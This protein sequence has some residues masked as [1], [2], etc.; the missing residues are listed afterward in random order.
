MDMRKK[1]FMSTLGGAA[2][3]LSPLTHCFEYD[4]SNDYALY[5]NDSSL[6]IANELSIFMWVKIDTNTTQY[7]IS[8][9]NTGANKR[10]FNVRYVAGGGFRV[11]ICESG[12]SAKIKIYDSPAS[13]IPLDV[14]RNIGFTFRDAGADGDLKL[15]MNTDEQSPTKT[16]DDTVNAIF[17]SNVHLI[18]GRLN[19]A[20]STYKF[21]GR[22]CGVTM[23]DTAV[24]TSPGINYLYNGGEAPDDL[25]GHP[26]I[27][28]IVS[29][30][31]IGTGDVYSSHVDQYGP[32]GGTTYG[33][34]EVNIVEDAPS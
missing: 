15:F 24:L 27:D 32:N 1:F 8:K 10:S 2:A 14:W 19:N 18:T 30:W 5:G 33:M 31:K 4:G 6:D 7:L 29:H 25:S 23:F 17:T 28:N 11:T 9:Y 21:K 12:T 13:I 20:T 16:R 3:P 34:S 22:L 26:D